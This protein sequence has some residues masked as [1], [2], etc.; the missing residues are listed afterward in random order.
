MEF[1]FEI[2]FQFLGEMLLQMLFEAIAE[3]GFH[4]LKDTFK[5]PR[6]PALSIIGFVIWGSLAGAVSLLIFPKSAITS[7][8]FRRVNLIATP[9]AVGGMM[10]VIG[11]LR[12]RRGTSLVRLDR[13]GYAFV[14]AFAM[15]TVRF[16]GA[17]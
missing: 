8:A 12:E 6:N 14:F 10:A 3:L 1:I 17:K 5:K 2:L 11:Q 7:I 9:L 15:A 4:G 16:L 13:F